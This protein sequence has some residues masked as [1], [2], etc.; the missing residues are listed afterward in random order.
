MPIVHLC[1]HI[2]SDGIPC[3][4]PAMRGLPLCFFHSRTFQPAR[5]RPRRKPL[6]DFRRRNIVLP[7]LNSHDAVLVA[8]QEIMQA[9]IEHRVDGE[10][11]N[12]LLYGI[13]TAI[14]ALDHHSTV[15]LLGTPSLPS[16]D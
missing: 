13:Q 14:T 7:E 16:E 11:A 2:K 1:E 4:S 15:P 8:L 9:V 5:R 12:S 3:G 6:I 10:R